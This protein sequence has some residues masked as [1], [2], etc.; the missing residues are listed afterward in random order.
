MMRIHRGERLPISPNNISRDVITSCWSQSPTERPSFSEVYKTLESL[1]N[2]SSASDRGYQAFSIAQ[3]NA[4]D[5]PKTEPNSPKVES[6]SPKAETLSKSE[7]IP[8]RT[9]PKIGSKPPEPLYE[10][11]SFYS[12]STNAPG[13]LPIGLPMMATSFNTQNTNMGVP[14]S[15]VTSPLES[16]TSGRYFNVIKEDLYNIT[17]ENPFVDTSKVF[18]NAVS[19]REISQTF[20]DWLFF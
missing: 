3:L 13:K 8:P 18:E 16:P 10:R 12:P 7:P 20:A 6:I 4:P 1:R 17:S 19:F 14:T 5:S 2:S 15:P 11:M 9:G